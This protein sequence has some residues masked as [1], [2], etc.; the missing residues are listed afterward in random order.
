MPAF[1]RTRLV[2]L[3]ALVWA[4]LPPTMAQDMPTP[5]MLA[6]LQALSEGNTNVP[7][8]AADDVRAHADAGN[9]EA[10]VILGL[11]YLAGAG[12]AHDHH[13]AMQWFEKAA[14]QN[15]ASA[16]I[17]LGMMHKN[18]HGVPVN[19]ALAREWLNRA[20]GQ[21]S[22]TAIEELMKLDEQAAGDDPRWLEA[23]IAYRL[24]YYRQA[25]NIMEPLADAGHTRAQYFLGAA[26]LGGTGVSQ[27]RDKG[28]TLI[29][30]ALP[31]LQAAAAQDDG[32][33]QLALATIYRQGWS[34]PADEAQAQHWREA[35]K[36]SLTAQA[37]NGDAEAQSD[38]AMLY[39]LDEN[40][41][42][43]AIPWLR[44]AAEQSD[45]H[46]QYWLGYALSYTGDKDESAHWLIQAAKF[47]HISARYWQLRNSEPP[48]S[49]DEKTRYFH[50]LQAIAEQGEPDAM[51]HLAEIYFQGF[52]T[53][54]SST[55]GLQWLEKAVDSG[56][57]PAQVAL[58]EHY[59]LTDEAR[60]RA[61]LKVARAQGDQ[62]AARKLE[63][64]NR[65]AIRQSGP[66]FGEVKRIWWSLF[67]P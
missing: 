18:G 11:M 34:V 64:L 51:V 61:L 43:A 54:V 10:Q 36:K 6:T 37:E 40:D 27:N 14:A 28:E 38:L 59:A 48:Q 67:E 33:A 39:W 56:Y 13:A 35:A 7:L 25:M 57:A 30:K 42:D 3:L 47:G 63:A 9:S 15:H 58:A 24:A 55:L 12:I 26:Y 20:A 8:P 17:A 62:E 46:S 49:E 22:A 45:P 44:K 52:G 32:E 23:E 65:N 29:G 50:Q 41:L 66:V 53:D 21:G 1:R 16:Q 31:G 5:D 2:A 19:H 60:A 4:G